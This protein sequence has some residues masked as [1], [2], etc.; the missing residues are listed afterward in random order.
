MTDCNAHLHAGAECV[1]AGAILRTWSNAIGRRAF[2]SIATC[3]TT[4]TRSHLLESCRTTSHPTPTRSGGINLPSLAHSHSRLSWLSLE[5]A[6]TQPHR[7][8]TSPTHGMQLRSHESFV[9]KGFDFRHESPSWIRN[10]VR[11]CNLFRSVQQL[12]P[13]SIHPLLFPI[14]TSSQSLFSSSWN[15]CYIFSQHILG[16]QSSLLHTGTSPSPIR[17]D[18]SRKP[19]DIGG[20]HSHANAQLGRKSHVGG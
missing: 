19:S 6:S 7:E 3:D 20:S 8:R 18:Q 9:I 14:L 2:N 17:L 12:S 10:C 5:S 13:N 15:I 16:Q 4:R 11:Q 1:K